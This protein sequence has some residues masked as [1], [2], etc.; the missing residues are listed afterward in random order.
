MLLTSTGVKKKHGIPFYV[1]FRVG[2]AATEPQHHPEI[3][4]AKQSP[5][6]Y[7]LLNDLLMPPTTRDVRYPV[8][9]ITGHGIRGRDL[10]LF[11]VMESIK[12]TRW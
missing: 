7:L 1:F 8:P 11:A 6:T 4:R 2:L 5:S 9:I 3:S 12:I 10:F